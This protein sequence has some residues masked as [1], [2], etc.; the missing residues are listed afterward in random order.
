MDR[1]KNTNRW[2]NRKTDRNIC[3]D[4]KSRKTIIQTEKMLKQVDTSRQ[5]DRE[6]SFNKTD[7]ETDS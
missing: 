7:R 6:N 4:S 3:P 5:L 2:T 1:Q